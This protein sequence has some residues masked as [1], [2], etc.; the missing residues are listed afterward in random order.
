MEDEFQDGEILI[1]ELYLNDELYD[2]H[3]K[4]HE[5]ALSVM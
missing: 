3:N 1:I 4:I 2:E 5:V